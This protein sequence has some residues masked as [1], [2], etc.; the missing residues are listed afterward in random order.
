MA[1]SELGLCL[2]LVEIVFGVPGINLYRLAAPDGSALPAFEPGAHLDLEIAPGLVR[3]YSLL[4]PQPAGDRYEIAVQEAPDGRGGS[5]CWHRQSV[6]GD[7]Y[8]ASLPRNHFALGAA[9]P[10]TRYLLAGGIGI[11]P[12]I[13]MYRKLVA[14]RQPVQLHY[15]TRSA[16][17]ALFHDELAGF[18]DGSVHLHSTQGPAPRLAD[19]LPSVPGDAPMYCCGPQRMI[20]AFD[21][22]TA[23]RPPELM[24]RERFAAAP[25]QAEPSGSFSIRLVRSGRTLEVGADESVL[26]ACIAAGV[27][28]SYSCEEGVCGA[29]EVRVLS[30]DVDHRDQVIPPAARATSATMMACCSRGRTMLELDI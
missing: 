15:W 24:H 14:Q 25:Q 7:V 5:R 17:S 29:C 8:R 4:W 9:T 13:S 2:R 28:L 6:V 26:S 21:A 22:L 20:D 23:R 10:A 3:Q 18:T 19:V 30:G 11:T 27:D 1:S 16:A 12:I